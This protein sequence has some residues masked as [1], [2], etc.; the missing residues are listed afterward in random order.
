VLFDKNVNTLIEYPAGASV[1][2]YSVPSTVS[3]LANYAF[4]NNSLTTVTF[5]AGMNSLGAGGF[6]YCTNLASAIFLGNAPTDPGFG[7]FNF[8]GNPV[9]YALTNASGWNPTFAGRPVVGL[10]GFLQTADSNFGLQANHFGF[11]ITGPANLVLVV[12]TCTNLVHPIW[13]PLQTNSI[14]QQGAFHFIDP[15]GVTGASRY[16]RVRFP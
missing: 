4:D 3:T 10:P 5:P 8:N 15:Q 14:T 1:G 7:F 16:Y 9:V 2:G 6:E 13:L 11:D 12:E